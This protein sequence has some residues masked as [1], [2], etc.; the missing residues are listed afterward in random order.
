MSGPSPALKSLGTSTCSRGPSRSP[1]TLAWKPR[2]EA[3]GEAK[4][5][6]A[7]GPHG[8]RSP[9]SAACRQKVHTPDRQRGVGQAAS[10]SQ[11]ERRRCWQESLSVS[12]CAAW[13]RQPRHSQT[14]T[15]GDALRSRAAPA[16]WT[17]QRVAT[18]RRVNRDPAYQRARKPGRGLPTGERPP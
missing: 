17:P 18:G 14:R 13:P 4:R 10:S 11:T 12:R 1:P 8:E 5:L 7:G 9:A 16:W 6:G 3:T 2:A 15:R